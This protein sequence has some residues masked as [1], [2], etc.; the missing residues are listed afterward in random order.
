LGDSV[1]LG[2]EGAPTGYGFGVALA[3]GDGAT[4]APELGGS[5][6]SGVVFLVSRVGGLSA[7]GDSPLV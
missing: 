3:E 7:L 1:G 5:E 2:L 6:D 4:P